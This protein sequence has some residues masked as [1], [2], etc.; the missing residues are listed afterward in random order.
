MGKEDGSNGHVAV[1]VPEEEGVAMLTAL[2]EE[3]QMV[4]E[5]STVSCWVSEPGLPSV[6]ESGSAFSFGCLL[7][8]HT[9]LGICGSK[10]PCH[11]LSPVWPS[12]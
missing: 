10:P 3:K 5:F 9:V 7:L 1:A 2:P 4:V 12:G 6:L 8:N 11:W